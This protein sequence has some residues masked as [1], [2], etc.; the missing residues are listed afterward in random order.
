MRVSR[1]IVLV[2][3][4]GCALGAG[5]GSGRH[6]QNGSG[7]VLQGGE[8][9]DSGA[10]SSAGA[11][12]TDAGGDPGP[13]SSTDDA[14]ADTSSGEDAGVPDLDADIGDVVILRDAHDAADDDAQDA[15]V[16]VYDSA[17]VDS[18]PP[19]EGPPDE[20]PP[21]VGPPDEGPPDTGN[22]T[23]GWTAALDIDFGGPLTSS[24]VGFAA[25]G[26]TPGDYWNAVVKGFSTD[27]TASSLLWTNGLPAGGV[28]AHV[29][30]LPGSWGQSAPVNDPMF[31]NYIY[32]SSGSTAT[33]TL[34][35]LP[36]GTYDFYAYGLAGTTQ[37]SGFTISI[38]SG[39]MGPVVFSS[40]T[41]YTST[42]SS[43]AGWVQGTQYVLLDGIP[44][45]DGQYVALVIS[46]GSQ[47]TGNAGCVL[48][49][50]QIMKY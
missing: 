32:S 43:P 21:D 8:T 16:D 9:A 29:Q 11:S 13:G 38:M 12:D 37:N 27:Y 39:P 19:D 23:T 5:C 47:G 20:G 50:L 49:G 42:G 34:A 28:S 24:E 48:N 46:N 1:V 35:G 31:N 4:G 30:N 33:V 25:A 26:L 3:M 40:G 45:A 22:P 14:A 18:G 6:G 7:P 36:G 2:A 17:P 41:K 15:G 10:T 44:V